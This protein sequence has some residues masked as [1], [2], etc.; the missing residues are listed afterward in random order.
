MPD[1][2]RASRSWQVSEHHFQEQL[3][4]LQHPQ[5]HL[6]RFPA[7]LGLQKHILNLVV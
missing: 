5:G 7:P 2:L 6:S 4:V 1:E 3:Q